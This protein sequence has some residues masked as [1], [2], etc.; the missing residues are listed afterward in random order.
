MKKYF[1]GVTTGMV[2]FILVAF[3][4]ATNINAQEN[5]APPRT[6]LDNLLTAYN[7][8]SNS[9]IRYLMFA[10]KAS[11]EGYD[12]VASLFRAIAFAEQVRY[13]RYAGIIKSLGGE[14]KADIETPVV[15]STMEN[16]ESGLKTESDEA[17]VTYPAFLKQA[18][19]ENIEDA[20]DAFED[21]IAA[22]S[23]YKQFYAQMLNNLSL[24]KGLVKDFLVCPVCGNV[25]DAIIW[26]KCP[27]CATDAKKFKRIK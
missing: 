24:S 21:A 11:V 27:I 22:E 10:E 9:H 4:G 12:V 1:F 19:K 20:I 8:E 16:L 18:K 25:V 17:K 23:V 5:A 6:T 3:L 26:S 13:E 14:P 15:N 2:L 7:S